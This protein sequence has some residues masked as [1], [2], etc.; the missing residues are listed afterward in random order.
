MYVKLQGHRESCM[1]M[2][3]KQAPLDVGFNLNP[4]P[5]TSNCRAT[6]RAACA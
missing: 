1:C 2:I 6:G 4:K 5:Y 3:C